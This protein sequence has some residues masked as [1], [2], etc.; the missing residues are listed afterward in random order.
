MK[1]CLHIWE[2][3]N[4]TPSGTPA[5]CRDCGASVVIPP[6]RLCKSCVLAT[7]C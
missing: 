5:R 1:A 2:W 4:N 7:I 3:E 6:V